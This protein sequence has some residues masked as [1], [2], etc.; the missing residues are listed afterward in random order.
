MVHVRPGQ[1]R[2]EIHLHPVADLHLSAYAPRLGTE[3]RGTRFLLETREGS[4]LGQL[5]ANDVT[6]PCPQGDYQ[7]LLSSSD[8][9]GVKVPVHIRSLSQWTFASD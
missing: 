8:T 1:D 6:L 5:L 4:V 9:A 2:L 3:L 7:L